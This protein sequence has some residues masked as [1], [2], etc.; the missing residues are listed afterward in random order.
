MRFAQSLSRTIAS[1]LYAAVRV[2]EIIQ[3]DAPA[4]A[5]ASEDFGAAFDLGEPQS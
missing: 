3:V 2:T 1:D 4:G 5:I